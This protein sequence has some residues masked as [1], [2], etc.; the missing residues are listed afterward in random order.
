MHLLINLLL[1][2]FKN[3]S[4]KEQIMRILIFGFIKNAFIV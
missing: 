1:K 3:A 2:V 4:A